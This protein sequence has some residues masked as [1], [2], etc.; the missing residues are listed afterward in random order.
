MNYNFQTAADLLSICGS[1]KLS[2][3]EV[4]IRREMA[5]DERSRAD[6]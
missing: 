1:E 2:L 5:M 4:M 3:A 6:I